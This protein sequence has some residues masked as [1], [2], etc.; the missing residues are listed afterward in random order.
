ME[1]RAEQRAESVASPRPGSQSV[2]GRGR[3][4][5][6]GRPSGFGPRGSEASAVGA[7]VQGRVFSLT[8]QEARDDPDVVSGTI[9]VAGQSCSVLFDSGAS[10]SFVS[11]SFLSRLPE[12][13]SF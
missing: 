11:E 6:A 10:H 1:V 7:P 8:Q 13:S 12:G 4:R 2:A 3:G 9:S 5:A